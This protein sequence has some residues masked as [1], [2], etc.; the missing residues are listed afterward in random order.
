MCKRGE[1]IKIEGRCRFRGSLKSEDTII[2]AS[3]Q[4]KQEVREDAREQVR[5]LVMACTKTYRANE[6]VELKDKSDLVKTRVT[7]RS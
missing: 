1:R 7:W 2:S 3:D 6:K 5:A 4:Q